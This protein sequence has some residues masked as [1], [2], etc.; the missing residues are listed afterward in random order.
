MQSIAG[1]AGL[2]PSHNPEIA[3]NRRRVLRETFAWLVRGPQARCT[4]RREVVA[5][6]HAHGASALA[7][8]Q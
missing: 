4:T 2:H 7:C 6:T 5:R 1:A 8:R 3:A